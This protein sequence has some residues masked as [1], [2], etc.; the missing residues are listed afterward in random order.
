M[1]YNMTS[2]TPHTI[3]IMVME[4]G[5]LAFETRLRNTS[6]FPISPSPDAQLAAGTG[7]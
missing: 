7:F 4:N 1:F 6:K 5:A 3:R 2:T